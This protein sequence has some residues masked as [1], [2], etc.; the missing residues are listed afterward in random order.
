[1]NA[2]AEART[3]ARIAA[4]GTAVPE[5]KLTQSEAGEF[6]MKHYGESL[7]ETKRAILKKIFQHP[8]VHERYYAFSD[9]EEVIEE[10]PDARISRFTRYAVDLSASS[11]RSAIKRAG[12]STEDVTG[13]VVNTCTGY[14]CPGLSTYLLERLALSSETRVYDLVGGGCGAAIPNL[15]MAAGLL[16]GQ[17]GAI[18]SVSVEI[19]TA[20]FQMGDDLSLIIS[21]ALFGDGAGA[22]VLWKRPGGLAVIDSAGWCAPEHREALRYVYKKGQLHNQLSLH[23]PE[24]VSPVIGKVIHTLLKRHGLKTTHIPHW[25]IHP[26]GDKIINAIQDELG[27]TEEQVRVSRTVLANFGNMSS[28]TVWF[29]LD[30]ILRNGIEHGEWC[31][32]VA[33]GAGMS[34]HACLLRNV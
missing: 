9:P 25:A 10:D 23:L 29:E 11:C 13:L 19:C 17:D 18:L 27:L 12:I 30:E 5:M 21:N 28:A 14:I 31:M 1:M 32:M 8:S 7:S 24:I 3:A 34:V 6:L 2:E 15:E 16:H 22:A 26:G 20:T 4:I 33:M